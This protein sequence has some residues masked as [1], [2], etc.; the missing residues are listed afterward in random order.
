MK[1][2]A[3]FIWLLLL[4]VHIPRFPRAQ[5]YGNEWY[6]PTQPYI[7]IG[8]LDRAW[9][10]VDFFLLE[11]YFREAGV[12][13]GAIPA[14][15]YQIWS[16]GKQ[17]PIRVVDGKDNRLDPGD[18][19]EFM[20]GPADGKIDRD[21]YIGGGEQP[22]SFR[23]LISDTAYYFIT[24]TARA[25]WLRYEHVA[26]DPVSAQLRPWYLH[27][28][29]ELEQSTYNRGTPQRVMDKDLFPSEYSPTEGWMGPVFGYGT[30]GYQPDH[31]FVFDTRGF[32]AAG[33]APLLTYYFSGTSAYAGRIDHRLQAKL[34]PNSRGPRTILDTSFRGH[35]GYNKTVKLFPSDLGSLFTELRLSPVNVTGIPYSY[36]Q[37]AYGL[38]RYPRFTHLNGANAIAFKVP[39]SIGAQHMSWA[40]PGPGL[41][42]PVVVNPEL[43]LRVSGR[44]FGNDSIVF[45][46]PVS[47][48]LTEW[49]LMD[50]LQYRLVSM[51]RDS[52]YKPVL[53]ELP[54]FSTHI[55]NA[56]YI[57]VTHPSLLGSETD[58]YL[59]YREGSFSAK[60]VTTEQL[61]NAFSYGRKHPVAIR[62]YA[63]YLINRSTIS[64]PRYLLLAGRGYETVYLKG[65]SLYQRRNLVPSIGVPAS[66]NIF[67]IGLNGNT[68]VPALATG[69]IP[70]E[71]KADIANYLEKVKEYESVL[72]RPW[73]KELIHLGG[74]TDASQSNYIKN[75]LDALKGTAEQ[76]LFSGRV[77]S[78][79][80]AATGQQTTGVKQGIVK[81]IN[82]G[83]SMITFLGHGS[84]QV[85]DIDMG[86]TADYFNSGRYPI[87][88]F[89]GCQIGN[90][91]IP[92]GSR[93]FFSERMLRGNRRGAVAF[94]SQS[95]LSELF[96]VSS[97]MGH[98]YEAYYN[99]EFGNRLGD[100]IK[101]SIQT[102]EEPGN[103]LNRIH[104]QQLF[105]MGDPALKFTAPDLPDYAI[106]EKSIYIDP[107]NAIA[108]SDSFRL[109]AVVNNYGRKV[110][111]SVDVWLRRTYP[112]GMTR[113]EYVVTIPP[114]AYQ[115]TAYIT[116]K[117]KDIATR[118][119]NTYEVEINPRR[120]TAEFSYS[121]NRASA[122]RFMPGNGVNLVYPRRFAIIG[123]DSVELVIQPSDLTVSNEQYFLELDTTPRFNSPWIKRSGATNSE[124]LLRMKFA[125]QPARDSMPYYWRAR[126]N[127]GS[128]EGG[129]W[130]ENSFT[131]IKGHGNGWMQQLAWQYSNRVS[132]NSAPGI[133][134]DTTA[135]Q[136]RFGSVVKKLYVDAQYGNK[137]NKGVKEGGFGGVDLNALNCANG[138]VCMLFDP[139]RNE[140]TWVDTSK[141][142]PLC[143]WG[144]TWTY[145]G[146]IDNYQLYY[147]F[148][149]ND[150]YWQDEFI[151]FI[152]LVPDSTYVAIF[153]SVFPFA[154]QWK[155]EVLQALNKIGSNVMDN[156][157]NRV[158]TSA[159]VC[160]GKKGTTPG[161]AQEDAAVFDGNPGSGYA[162]VEAELYGARNSGSMVSEPIGPAGSW[163]DLHYHPDERNDATDQMRV[164]VIGIDRRGREQVLIA[165]ARHHEDLRS[166]DSN[167]YRFIKL[168]V[169]LNDKFASTP[170]Q[171]RNWRVT[172]TDVPEGTLYPLTRLGYRYYRDTL[173]E[174]DTFRLR[175]P[176]HNLSRLAFRD[177][178]RARIRISSRDNQ[179]LLYSDSV[180]LPPLKPGETALFSS[181]LGT[182]GVRGYHSAVIEVNPV[183]LQSELTLQN[184][185]H[186]FT[187]FVQKDL[188]G[189]LLDV[190]FDGRRI[191]SGEIVK[192]EPLIR[193]SS[194]DENRFLLQTDSARLEVYLKKPGE[195]DFTRIAVDGEQLRFIP[196]SGPE[197]KAAMEFR[198]VGLRDGVHTLRVQSS[199]ASSNAAGRQEYE[200]AFQIVTASTV[201][202]FYPYPNPFTSQ[203][204]FVFTLTGES[205]P[206][207][208]R[209][210]I[211][212]SD[213]RVVRQ[214]SQQELGPLHIGNNIS[215]WSWDG[216]D[217]FGDRLANGVY[218]YHV[219]VKKNG[220]DLELRNT[221][222]DEAFKDQV[223]KIY[224]M[225]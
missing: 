20:G 172:F 96:A 131:Y 145:F 181:A 70:A 158:A 138:L 40:N 91:C 62:R 81:A 152:S 202:H 46:L 13:V 88:Y 137:S 30:G 19:I 52:V 192:P 162:A 154:D 11:W 76:G 51:D 139:N 129:R 85:T 135:K 169:D 200:S 136:L 210:K 2:R 122:R 25:P 86:D 212:T 98:F 3:R 133:V 220:K 219:S 105:L 109:A 128:P 222:G 168:R 120:Q 41:R 84:T 217:Q 44:R 61:Y 31:A 55:N 116:I 196:A 79:H 103:L 57:I 63:A 148:P 50:S 114:V 171:L 49:V 184:N 140:L 38:L 29:L 124:P 74:G 101:R 45:D 106:T 17:I 56:E 68:Q 204:R 214:V 150:P 155:P 183:F 69:R 8:V 211:M 223:G 34:T 176:F 126:I 113:R 205:I 144:R 112:D 143:Y 73:Q 28:E 33:P 191:Y 102:Y 21:M 53:A 125:L 43:G 72:Y 149:M 107:T 115:D 215:A 156:P 111:D 59:R 224:L 147:T 47:P 89:N 174:G 71:S 97:Q 195:T 12:S 179:A 22:Q 99:T 65:S 117:S 180:M 39:S 100:V 24:F 175:I 7:R 110:S 141:M 10:R 37:A 95:A 177:S 198:P 194:K 4:L 186:V 80:K 94:L 15:R 119:D 14:S 64:P 26:P 23:S 9:Y 36:Y 165:S 58:A 82:N 121:N 142:K 151:R 108:L 163:L 16:D 193:I 199:D 87:C 159:F 93:V 161:S 130:T 134:I 153:S 218:F 206:D 132:R 90:P 32:N 66:D 42:F 173:Y 166:I 92:Y 160:V 197:N 182:T 27:E 225:R 201:T 18:Y 35:S 104:C 185:S 60:L 221:R 167:T 5:V 67:S 216:T 146:H 78:W 209:I 213:G 208:I 118:G 164:S 178:I 123:T 188:M 75:R 127:T 1:N 190:Q 6:D 189:P 170:M 48:H 77:S 187:Y 54:D 157:A 83:V 207:D 203:M